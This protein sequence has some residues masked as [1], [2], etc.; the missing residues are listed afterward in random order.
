ML[1]DRLV[2]LDG[3]IRNTLKDRQR[4]LLPY[5]IRAMAKNTLKIP[6]IRE[7]INQ[8][9][10]EKT[11][12]T[13]LQVSDFTTVAAIAFL[14][15]FPRRQAVQIVAQTARDYA[16]DPSFLDASGHRLNMNQ[17][18]RRAQHA[19]AFHRYATLLR[20]SS[21]ESLFVERSQKVLLWQRR[22]N[23]VRKF[24]LPQAIATN[25]PTPAE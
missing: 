7:T 16:H 19:R 14:Q 9:G 13:A 8:K 17:L 1:R 15:G 21:I 25:S 18:K 4:A 24:F 12:E 20:K 11:L 22:Y 5:P 2:S 6:H 3:A 23:K 10:I